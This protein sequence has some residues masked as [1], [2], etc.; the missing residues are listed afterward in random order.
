[1]LQVAPI[2]WNKECR[3][4]LPV[5]E[6]KNLMDVHYPNAISLN[7]RRDLFDE[8]YRFKM[9]AGLPTFDDAI[10]CMLA[11]AERERPVS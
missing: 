10:E 11:L 4:R 9:R 3:F 8:L 7:L 5:Q 6:W 1:V 2:S